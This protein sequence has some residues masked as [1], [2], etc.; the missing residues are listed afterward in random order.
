MRIIAD[1]VPPDLAGT[2]QALY[3]TVGIGGATALLTIISGWL[4]ARFG[5][6]GFWVMAFLSAAAL[7]VIWSLQRTLSRAQPQR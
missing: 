2:A 5:P 7:P 4:F 1:T 3:G 6:A